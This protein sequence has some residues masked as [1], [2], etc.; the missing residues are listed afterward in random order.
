MV[1]V[2]LMGCRVFTYKHSHEPAEPHGLLL[3][4]L[5]SASTAITIHSYADAA[6]A[7]SIVYEIP[8]TRQRGGS[9]GSSQIWSI[10]GIQQK[11]L[12]GPS[13]HV[14]KKQISK[15]SAIALAAVCKRFA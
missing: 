6:A 1:T 15:T 8:R 5:R 3:L 10:D 2:M 4:L 12:E 13:Q 11:C 9:S 14:C 7:S